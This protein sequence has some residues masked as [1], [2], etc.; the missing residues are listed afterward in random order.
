MQTMYNGPRWE[1]WMKSITWRNLEHMMRLQNSKY[2]KRVKECQTKGSRKFSTQKL[3]E[4]TIMGRV[5]KV[6]VL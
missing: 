2:M 6:P 1:V 5:R 3:L 4:L